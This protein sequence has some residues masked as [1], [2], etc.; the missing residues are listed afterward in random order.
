MAERLTYPDKNSNSS[1]ASEKKFFDTE[2]NQIKFVTDDH[3]TRIENLEQNTVN[4]VNPY[5]GRYTSLAILQQA[6]PTAVVNAFAIIDAGPGVTPQI[7]AWDD[8]AQVWELSNAALNETVFPNSYAD[9]PTPGVENVRYITINNYLEYVWHNNQYRLIGQALNT[10]YNRLKVREV[11]D[12]LL[13]GTAEINGIGFQYSGNSITH[14]VFNEVF[15]QYGLKFKE[16]QEASLKSY[17]LYLYN[18][19]QQ[20]TLQ[21]DITSY[22]INTVQSK[23]YLKL[24]IAANAIPV[25]DVVT[26]D[27]VIVDFKECSS[28]GAS[29][30]NQEDITGTR[31]VNANASGAINLD[32]NAFEKWRLTLTAATDLTITNLPTG[33][34]TKVI[35]VEATG[36]F[37]L[38][39]TNTVIEDPDNDTYD[40]AKWNRLLFELE[41]DRIRMFLKNLA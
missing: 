20:K 11:Q 33:D 37:P 10:L 17:S 9:L 3:A 1:L 28:G 7:A 35:E 32:V 12:T 14:V 21:A 2:A 39:V 30:P 15:T 27:F 16:L 4:S 6:H 36:A 8:Q 34:N 40:G 38:A 31:Q 13:E 25:A 26:E 19:V 24:T 5:Y 29:I 41:S 22:E 23:D 18:T